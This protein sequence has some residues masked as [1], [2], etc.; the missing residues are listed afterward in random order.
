M[1]IWHDP[2]RQLIM[3]RIMM[4]NFKEIEYPRNK[5]QNH[6]ITTRNPFLLLTLKSA[7]EPENNNQMYG[8]W[9]W[10]TSA[11]KHNPIYKMGKTEHEK[12][13]WLWFLIFWEYKK[14][15]GTPIFFLY[16][17]YWHFF[18]LFSFFFLN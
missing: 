4:E 1:L 18:I 9:K 5:A 14:K 2:N 10:W 17:F 8:H 13:E 3:S 7:S 6:A 12:V 16:F 15:R 11:H